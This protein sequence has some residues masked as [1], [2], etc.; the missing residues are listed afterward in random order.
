MALKLRASLNYGTR[1]ITI[2][3][4]LMHWICHWLY[5]RDLKN[6][7][8][9]ARMLIESLQNI[10]WLLWHLFYIIDDQLLQFISWQ[11]QSEWESE[12]GVLSSDWLEL[13]PV[14]ASVCVGL[15]VHVGCSDEN[16]D[17]ETLSHHLQVMSEL[18][19][20]DKNHASVMI[21][22]VANEPA[23]TKPLAQHYFK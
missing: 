4:L 19:N 2:V 5:H 22:S 6:K 1:C 13:L 21:W 23:S 3:T 15:C 11:S 18:V 7:R 20:R 9:S 10:R 8:R 12:R 17:N 14:T 16:F